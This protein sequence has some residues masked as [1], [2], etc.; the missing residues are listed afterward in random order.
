MPKP[1]FLIIDDEH[2]ILTMF[3]RALELDGYETATATSAEAA[4]ELINEA[5]PDAIMLDL[6]MPYV[7]GLGLLYRLRERHPEIA[8]TIVTGLSNLDETMRSEIRA[9]KAELRFKPLRIAEIQTI[10]RELLARRHQA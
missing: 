2:E 5:P 10:A 3:S 9:L 6:N 7:N 4:I 1:R 8:V